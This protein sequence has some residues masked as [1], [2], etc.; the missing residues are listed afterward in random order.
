M[1]CCLTWCHMWIPQVLFMCFLLE[2]HTNPRPPTSRY[3]I[4]KDWV[5]GCLWCGPKLCHLP[6]QSLLQCQIH[7]N[8]IPPTPKWAARTI[9]S[10]F[11]CKNNPLH[12]TSPS[13]HSKSLATYG[14]LKFY[15]FFAAILQWLRGHSA[16]L[17]LP[18]D[19][20]DDPLSWQLHFISRCCRFSSHAD[21]GSK[22]WWLTSLAG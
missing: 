18:Q 10:C 4:V 1:S 5:F 12:C 6:C 8:P 20:G 15:L 11:S 19:G 7:L 14:C 17:V 13:P 9:N 21:S 2:H 3:V 22:G 16:H